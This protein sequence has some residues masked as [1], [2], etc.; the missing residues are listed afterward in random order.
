LVKSTALSSCIAILAAIKLQPSQ[1]DRGA[2]G[3]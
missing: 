1:V 2:V 3:F